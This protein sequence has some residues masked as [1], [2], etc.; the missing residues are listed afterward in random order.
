MNVIAV[1]PGY[2]QSAYVVYDGKTI[3][4]HATVP[5]AQLLQEIPTHVGVLVIEQIAA[6]GMSVGEEVFE[7]VFWSGR[8]AQ[9]FRGKFERVKRHTVKMHL[10]GNM[11]ANDSNIR[12]ALLDRFG[13]GRE[14]AM[15]VKRAPGPLYGIAGDQWAALAVAVTWWDTQ[16]QQHT[17]KVG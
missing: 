11:R 16:L 9:A 5:N 10:C 14:R 13:P 2:T 3:H 17:R 7:T 8:F 4:A 6:M 15:G 12:Q 1:D